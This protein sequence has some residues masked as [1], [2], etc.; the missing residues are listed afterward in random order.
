MDDPNYPGSSPS[1]PNPPPYSEKEPYDQ[2]PPPAYEPANPAMPTQYPPYYVPYG[3]VPGYEPV[4]QP[5]LHTT[6]IVPVQ[7]PHAPD[8]LAYSIFT[9]LFCFL[10]L[11][12]GA[13]VYSLRTRDAN[14][15]G[16]AAEA[17]RNSRTARTLAHSALFVGI[18]LAKIIIIFILVSR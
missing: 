4:V 2:Q 14:Q 1:A 7:P 12:I 6:V 9:M 10:P 18:V 11:G 13:L 8:H 5:L 17:Q 16:N 15:M 3:A